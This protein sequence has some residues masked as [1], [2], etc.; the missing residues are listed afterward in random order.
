MD[1]LIAPGCIAIDNKNRLFVADNHW[2]TIFLFDKDQ[3]FVPVFGRTSIASDFDSKISSGSFKLDEI[4]SMTINPNG[5]IYI[6]ET[7]GYRIWLLKA[8][9]NA[10]IVAGN[11]EEG[12]TND[13][14]NIKEN[15]IGAVYSMTAD[16]FGELIFFDASRL[17]LRKIRKD[18]TLLTIGGNNRM[19]YTADGISFFNTALS[20]V[21]GLA[22][23]SNN[24]LFFCDRSFNIVRK[25]DQNNNVSLVC[26]VAETDGFSGIIGPANEMKLDSPTKILIDSD[27]FL[28]IVDRGNKRICSI[29]L[30]K[31]PLIAETFVGNYRQAAINSENLFFNDIYDITKSQSGELYFTDSGNGNIYK[32]GDDAK[33]TP[34]PTEIYIP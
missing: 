9:Y 8:D 21:Y 33:I 1:K 7:F 11:G 6:A 14:E 23:D 4:R 3:Y 15:N 5:G 31:K 29:N 28:Y 24:N 20:D 32:I 18:G 13:C 16:R 22:Y 25:V 10:N 26:G 19:E 27:D 17:L 12:F 2:N 34:L 30:R